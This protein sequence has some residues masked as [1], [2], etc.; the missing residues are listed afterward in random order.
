MNNEHKVD[1]EHNREKKFIYHV[2]FTYGHIYV[3]THINFVIS[4]YI[5]VSIYE[6]RY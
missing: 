6:G 3:R 2:L 4:L 5:S 1:G